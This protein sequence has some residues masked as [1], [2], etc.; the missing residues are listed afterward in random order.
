MKFRF[1]S[2]AFVV[3]T[4]LV[5]FAA[6][7]QADPSDPTGQWYLSANHFAL[8][9]NISSPSP[10]VYKG[11]MTNDR[12]G[13]EVL[14]NISWDKATRVLVFRRVGTGFW[15]WY[16]GKIV[17]GIFVGRFSH[18]ASSRE[19]P[20]QLTDYSWHATGWNSTYLDAS[21]VP[22]VWEILINKTDRARLRIDRGSNGLIGRLKVYSTV[23]G[24]AAG[25][26][27]EYDLDAITWDGTRL[28]FAQHLGA[29]TAPTYRGTIS[30][31]DIS[32][33]I[34]PGE[35]TFSGT[36][37]EVLTYGTAAKSAAARARWADR[38]RRQL[39]HLMMAG[40]PEP[41]SR[42]VT[43]LNA[44]IAPTPSVSPPPDRDDNPAAWPQN[45]TKTELR[46]DYTLPNP[47]GGAPIARSSHAYLTVPNSPPPAGGR[48][49]ALLAVNGHDGSAW[50]MMNPDD[51]YFWYGDSFARRGF[52]VLAVDIS[53]RPLEDRAKL[54]DGYPNGDD[55]DHGNGAH[56]A[57]KAEGFDSDW[58]EDGDRSW[59]TMRAVDYL[60]TLP[61]VDQ[62]RIIISGISLGGEVTAITGGLDPRFAMS[63]PVGYSPDEGVMRYQGNHECWEWLHADIRDY[64]DISDYFALT[65]PRPLLIEAGRADPCFSMRKPPYS[66]D[67]QVARRN[68]AAYGAEAAR[69]NLYLHYDQHHYHVGDINPTSATERGVLVPDKLAPAEPWSQSWQTEGS[70][71]TLQP[72]LF[73]AIK[74]LLP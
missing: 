40:N 7:A 59:D 74:S 31:R 38:T 12:D 44:K 19:I 53:H 34:S 21:I 13:S 52:V 41:L 30:G 26:Q 17:E 48:Y 46:F 3:S 2:A 47:Y 37:A 4:V 28:S 36:R 69:F 64:V 63:I 68:I 61:N 22:R 57:V 11:T 51:P 50:K 24:G 14:D 49:P 15:Q 42:H 9:V 43:V 16:S 32:G 67:K 8:S 72:T 65:A 18:S 1:I 39:Y 6:P 45:Y 10:G 25:E 56:P 60:I 58:E 55:P 70:M 20:A 33:T 73:D 62:K 66:S 27:L 5:S 54:Y 71:H 29:K 23:S 35:G